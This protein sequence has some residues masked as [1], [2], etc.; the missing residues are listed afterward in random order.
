MPLE[1]ILSVFVLLAVTLLVLAAAWLFTRWAGNHLGGG[2]PGTMSGCGKIE[3]LDRVSL[4]R[5]HAL[6]VVRA[7]ERYLLLGS[8]P[9]ELSLISELSQEEG[10][11]WKPP[12]AT[13]QPGSL[14]DFRALMQRLKEKTDHSGR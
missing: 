4:S 13:K 14:P 5:D 7:G 8:T 1:Q 9:S 3:I 10:E 12:A 2:L 6:L 11:N